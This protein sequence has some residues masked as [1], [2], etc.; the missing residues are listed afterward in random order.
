MSGPAKT[1]SPIRLIGISQTHP[2][3][4]K[5]E[6]LA[7]LRQH[8]P[9]LQAKGLANLRLFGSVVRSGEESSEA[10][11]DLLVASVAAR[12]A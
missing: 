9:E 10:D 6:I 4:T 2:E 7:T 3:M 5:D 8:A 1:S 12:F 11:I